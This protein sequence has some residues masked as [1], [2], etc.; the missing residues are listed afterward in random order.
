LD[1]IEDATLLSAR[2]EVPAS[3]SLD[4]VVRDGRVF[5]AEASPSLRVRYSPRV[6]RW[7]AEREHVARDANGSVTVEYP[8]ADVHWAVRHVLQYGPDAEVLAPD[9]VRLAIRARL[10]RILAAESDPRAGERYQ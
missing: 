9:A 4:S 7:I 3:F 1:R 8:L 10:E 6:A 2:Y 5:Q